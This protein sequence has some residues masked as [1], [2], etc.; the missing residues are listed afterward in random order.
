MTT[1]DHAASDPGP[2]NAGRRTFNVVVDG[3]PLTVTVTPVEDASE[4]RAWTPGDGNF[5]VSVDGRAFRVQVESEA[6]PSAGTDVLNAPPPVSAAPQS[7]S[8]VPATP[9]PRQQASPALSPVTSEAAKVGE[10]VLTAPI[11]GT[12]VRYTVSEA[13]PV[14]AG[15]PVVVLEA[16]KMENTLPAPVDGVVKQIPLQAG[17]KVARGD[18]LAV[19]GSA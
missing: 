13:Q 5:Q 18:I 10:T 2:S 7:P 9:T 16:M 17:A 11:P 3:I 15:D 14:K 19:I 8:P 1:E 12:I 6:L 4:D